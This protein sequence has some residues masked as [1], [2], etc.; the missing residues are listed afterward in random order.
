MKRPTVLRIA[1]AAAVLVQFWALYVPRA[2]GVPTGLPLDKLVHL[3]LF[4]VVTYLGLRAGMPVR[5]LAPLTV[6]QAA[7]SE[8]VQHFYLPQR[9]GDWWDFAADLAGIA[10]AVW[11]GRG[12]T[13]TGSGPTGRPTSASR[14]RSAV[15]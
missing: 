9:G 14:Q 12:R 13:H 11:W 3:T 8:L 2:P 6:L 7:A 4:A 15:Q 1:F 10:V 5:W